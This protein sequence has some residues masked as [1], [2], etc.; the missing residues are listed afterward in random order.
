MLV[1]IMFVYNFYI[2]MQGLIY[3]FF[4]PNLIILALKILKL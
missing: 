3:C 4:L 2:F 1:F